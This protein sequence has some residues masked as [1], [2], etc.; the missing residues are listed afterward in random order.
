MYDLILVFK[1]KDRI[2]FSELSFDEVQKM[3][4]DFHANRNLKII[5]KI[6]NYLHFFKSENIN[7]LSIKQE[8]ETKC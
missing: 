5:S 3:I 1:N 7:Y 6:S 8:T 2:S 4:S